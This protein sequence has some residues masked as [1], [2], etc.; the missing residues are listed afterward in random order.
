MKLVLFPIAMNRSS[1]Y[2][3]I[4]CPAI[5]AKLRCCEIPCQVDK[6]ARRACARIADATIPWFDLP[7]TQS[8]L[9]SAELF[10]LLS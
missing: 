8:E 3:P 1:G 7:N 6:V 9:A 5:S 2:N 10:G 4:C